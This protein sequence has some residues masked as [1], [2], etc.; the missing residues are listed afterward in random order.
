MNRARPHAGPY[1]ICIVDPL[2]RGHMILRGTLDE[3][4]KIARLYKVASHRLNP[5]GYPG[6]APYA[7]QE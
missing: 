5:P 2:I 4:A 3:I 6:H 7:S 1:R